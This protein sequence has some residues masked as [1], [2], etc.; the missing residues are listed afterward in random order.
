M[1]VLLVRLWVR[2]GAYLEDWAGDTGDD[3]RG[4]GE[5]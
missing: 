3:L 2:L 4:F 1:A 5:R